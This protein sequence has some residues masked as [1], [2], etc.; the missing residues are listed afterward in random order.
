MFST[1][2]LCWVKSSW[3][4]NP[5]S[6]ALSTIAAKMI[7]KIYC[8]EEWFGTTNYLKI[9]THVLLQTG[10]NLWQQHYKENVLLE[11]FLQ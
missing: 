6:A 7:T 3:L 10:T 2:L 5:T 8:T 4:R 9:T 1:R 11:L